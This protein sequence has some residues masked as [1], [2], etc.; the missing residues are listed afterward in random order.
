MNCIYCYKSLRCCKR[1]DFVERNFHF[2]CK[3]RDEKIK[4]D[5]AMEEFCRWFME[6][7]KLL[8]VG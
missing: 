5:I 1:V 6:N 4:K 7:R 2:S 3:N 8:I